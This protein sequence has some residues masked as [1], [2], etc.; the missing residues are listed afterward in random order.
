MVMAG[1]APAR[2]ADLFVERFDRPGP[3]VDR[4]VWTTFEGPAGYI[5]RTAFRNPGATPDG[6]GRITVRDGHAVLVLSRFNPTAHMPGDSFWGSHLA[7]RHAF[8]PP[9]RDQGIELMVRLRTPQPLPRGIVIGVFLFGLTRGAESNFK[10]EIDVEFLTN[11]FSAAPVPWVLLNRYANEPPGAGHPLYVPVTG[12]D[13][14]R[15]TEVV[16]RWF[17]HRP[18]IEWMI[19]GRLLRR[20]TE[21]VPREPMA[22]HLNIWAPEPGFEAAYDAALQPTQS[23]RDD[24][25]HSIVLIDEVRVRTVPVPR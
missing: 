4:T 24:D 11:G 7:T 10:S 13:L 1:A 18:L 22:V 25:A 9:A 3:D 21:V 6:R 14:T 16:L 23:A 17:P 15:P 2:A 8:F 12:L 19:D 5:P 20:A